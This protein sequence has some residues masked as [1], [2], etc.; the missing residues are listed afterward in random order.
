[1]FFH[2][3]WLLSRMFCFLLCLMQ[4]WNYSDATD[5]VVNRKKLYPGFVG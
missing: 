1:M 4:N 3:F 2:S 5:V